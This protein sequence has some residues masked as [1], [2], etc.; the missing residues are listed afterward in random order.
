M[1]TTSHALVAQPAASRAGGRGKRLLA[2]LYGASDHLD[3][4]E[5]LVPASDSTRNRL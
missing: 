3:P 1:A 2:K 4:G 5:L